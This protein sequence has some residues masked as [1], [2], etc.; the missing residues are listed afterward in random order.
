MVEFL[1]HEFWRC[2]LQLVQLPCVLCDILV[3]SRLIFCQGSSVG[4]DGI[5]SRFSPLVSR[6]VHHV[7]DE[8]WLAV[9]QHM[10]HW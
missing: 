4:Q 9:V 5:C 2:I 3:L 7:L 10:V 8:A 6:I 1:R